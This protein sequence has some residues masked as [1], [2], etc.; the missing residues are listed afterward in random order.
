MLQS[1]D[2]DIWSRARVGGYVVVTADA[3]FYELAMTHGPPPKVIWLRNCDYPTSAAERLLR[4]NAIR[5]AEFG[6]DD[7][8]AV[9]ILTK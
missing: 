5:V 2:T 9:L 1:P 6:K 7:Q 3:D 4:D 8:Q